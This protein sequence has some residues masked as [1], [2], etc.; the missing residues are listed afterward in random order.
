MMKIKLWALFFLLLTLACTD[1]TK[2]KSQTKKPL[3]II[4]LI[5]DGMGL[6]QVSSAYYF[7]EGKVNFS[8]FSKIGLINTSAA[9]QKITDSAASATAYSCGQRTFK[10][11]IGMSVD[12]VPMQSMTDT[13]SALNYRTGIVVTSAVTDATPAA[14][15]GHVPSRYQY[16]ELASQLAVSSIDFVAGGGLENFTQREDGTNQLA[17]MEEN[18]FIVD[19]VSL[20]RFEADPE[21]KY[22]FFLSHEN[23]PKMPEK[24]GDY[25][26]QATQMAI[27]YLSKSEDGFFLMVEGSQIDWAGHRNNAEHLITEVIDFDETI[28]KALDFAEKDGNT[29]VIVTADHETGGFALAGDQYEDIRFATTQ[30][31]AALVPV[32]AFGPGAEHF[33]GTFNNN[34]VRNKIFQAMHEIE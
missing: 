4:L 5:G 32:F 34:E 11:V 8:R 1:G 28:G 7:K 10:K 31:T 13:L 9:V 3:N 15:Y 23:M 2:N 27:D 19:T 6:S 33:T 26:P 20:D 17:T 18:G 25:L 14:F 16:E 30:H 12:M 29:L 24:R 21:K 22:A